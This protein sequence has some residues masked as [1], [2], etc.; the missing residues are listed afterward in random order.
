MGDHRRVNFARVTIEID[1][2]ARRFRNQQLMLSILQASG[3]H[4][5]ETVFQERQLVGRQSGLH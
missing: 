5:R 2:C 4:V 3:K 1:P